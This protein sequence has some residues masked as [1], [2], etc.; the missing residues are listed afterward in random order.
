MGVRLRA[1][2]R[3]RYRPQTSD[4]SVIDRDG[5]PVQPDSEKTGAFQPDVPGKFRMEPG[6]SGSAPEIFRISCSGVPE[7]RVP[8]PGYRARSVSRY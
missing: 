7:N 3:T 5:N 1:R 8:I 4:L 2:Q 6:K